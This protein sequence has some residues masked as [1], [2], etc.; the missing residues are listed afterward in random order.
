[1]PKIIQFLHPGTEHSDKSGQIWNPHPPHKRKFVSWNGDYIESLSSKLKKGDIDF[2]CEWEAE[3]TLLKTTNRNN[4]FP[5]NLFSPYY[6]HY[7]QGKNCENTDPFVFGDK[8]YY[9]ICRQGNEKMRNLEKG[10]LILF[11]SNINQKFVLDTVFIVK[12]DIPY[13]KNNFNHLKGKTN[14]AFFETA[15]LPVVYNQNSNDRYNRCKLDNTQ[16]KVYE[17]QMYSEKGNIFSYVPCKIHSDS[18]GFER[19]V[20]KHKDYIS[21]RLNQNLMYSNN[22]T[23]NDIEKFWNKI[24]EDLLKKGFSLM[25][26]CE[27]PKQK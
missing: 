24:T 4:R 7:V 11:G 13:M 20:V 6:T 3:S 15:I 5:R 18:W 12:D 26:S 27:L 23:L 17:G 2:W 22:V 21:D 16:Y 8:F 14:D 25:T 19:P 10:T 9:S 1:M